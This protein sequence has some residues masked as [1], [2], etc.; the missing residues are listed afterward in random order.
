MH[1][2][3]RNLLVLALLVAFS[4]KYIWDTGEPPLIGTACI[5]YFASRYLQ[6]SWSAP[7]GDAADRF[8]NRRLQKKD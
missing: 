8:I 6:A 5:V 2:P 4:G 3:D 1:C 7:G